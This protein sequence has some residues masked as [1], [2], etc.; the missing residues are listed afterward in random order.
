MPRLVATAVLALLWTAVAAAGDV[1]PRRA[2]DL[3][4][5]GAL[6][7]LQRS[8]PTHYEKVRQILQGVLQRPDTDVPRWI[9][10]NFAANDVSYVPVVLTSHPPKRRLS[11]ALDATRY[12]AVVI[13]TNV[14][15]DITPAK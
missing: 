7:A 6:E 10:A 14:R 9:R 13:L 1:T 8:N 3:N 12:E 2:I 11:F 4:E 15:G 5:P